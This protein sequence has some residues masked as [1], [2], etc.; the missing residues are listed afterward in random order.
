MLDVRVLNLINL[1]VKNIQFSTKN[2]VLL[3]THSF[4]LRKFVIIEE[5]VSQ[6]NIITI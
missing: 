5:E 2:H 4:I 1:N 3:N 6:F